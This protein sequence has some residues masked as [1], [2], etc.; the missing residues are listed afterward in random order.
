MIAREVELL[1]EDGAKD[2]LRQLLDA[3]DDLDD[4]DY[5]G[6]KG[7]RHFLDIEEKD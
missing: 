1:S 6:A 5:F 7:W 2:Y 3:L 4:E